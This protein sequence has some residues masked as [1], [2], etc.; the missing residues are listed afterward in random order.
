MDN[1]IL[2]YVNALELPDPPPQL[3]SA[4]S[5]EPIHFGNETQAVAVASQIT[6]FDAAV[7]PAHRAVVAD[8]LLL[9]Q[10]AADKAT[11]MNHDMAAW[12]EHFRITLTKLGWLPTAMEFKDTV[13]TNQD[14]DLHQAIIPVLTTMLGP[15]TAA[16]AMV[17][18][19]LE[20][21]QKMDAD[22]PWIKL[23]GRSSS[24]A[25]GAK[26]QLSQVDA[27]GD[28]VRV[29]MVA[30][31]INAEHTITQVL[32]FKFASDNA[33]LTSAECGLAAPAKR[34]E[35]IAK[36]VAGRVEPFLLDNISEIVV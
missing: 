10:L 27:D 20:G 26:C 23:F 19:V 14:A 30:L 16:A 21:L 13:V 35:S 33:R 7:A 11:S 18:S 25:T 36:A 24:H 15:A 4:E 2:D 5:A 32:F 9:A 22:K 29:H 3:E 8:C 17:V 6:A 28:T 1:A 12:Y 34:L 31:A